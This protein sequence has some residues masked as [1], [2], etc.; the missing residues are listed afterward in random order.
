[1]PI[2]F[3]R[4]LLRCFPAR[5]SRSQAGAVN[6]RTNNTWSPK[7]NVMF[8]TGEWGGRR[9]W[10]EAVTFSRPRLGITGKIVPAK[11]PVSREALKLPKTMF[12]AGAVELVAKTSRTPTPVHTNFAGVHI[13]SYS[14][15]AGS[16]DRVL[17]K[18][19]ILPVPCS[20][21]LGATASLEKAAFPNLSINL[22]RR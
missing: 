8:L 5:P 10:N 16:I 21:R 20:A 3:I 9:T 6:L 7:P 4:E 14:S 18:N 2:F 12:W 17:F 13:R 1:M 15:L 22:S 19:T 11:L